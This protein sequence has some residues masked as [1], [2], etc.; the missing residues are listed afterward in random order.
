VLRVGA[1][2]VYQM[3]TCGGDAELELANSMDP[4]ADVSP[5]AGRWRGLEQAARHGRKVLPGRAAAV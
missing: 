3:I 1:Q 4:F 2:E 5:K